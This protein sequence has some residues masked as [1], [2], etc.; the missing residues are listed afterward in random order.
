MPKELPTLMKSIDP[1]ARSWQKKLHEI[2]YEAD[3]PGGKAFDIALLVAIVVS[4]IAVMLESVP[5]IGASWGSELRFA[6]WI[7]TIL[8]TIEYVLR[9]ISVRRPAKYATSFFGIVDVVAIIPTYLTLLPVFGGAHGLIVI[10]SLRLI[11]VF[12]IFKL[13]RYMSEAQALMVALRATAAKI[14]VFFTLVITIMLILGSLMYIIEG[15][16]PES[17]FTSIP[18]GV[19]W[20]IVTMT[21]VGYGDVTPQTIPGQFLAAV[22]MILGYSII[23]VPTGIFSVEVIMS[24]ERSASTQACPSC[25]REGHD[26]NSE[27]CKYCGEP[28]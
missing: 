4:V 24:R 27:F 20:A 13:V 23:I 22:A 10:R 25:S 14:I 19:Y 11:R 16:H 12:R 15:T 2:I 18:K 5:S 28:L 8:F 26:E 17:Q 3:T 21:T 6:E 7:F 1:G 9:L